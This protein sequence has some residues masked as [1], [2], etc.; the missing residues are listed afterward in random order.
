MDGVT[1]LHP[2]RQ[3][4]GPAPVHRH[5]DGAVECHPGHEPAKDERAATTP[6][7]PDA[8]VGLVPVL[9]QPVE[10]AD[11]VVPG[12]VADTRRPE[13]AGV[14]D[15]DGV[16]RLAVDVQLELIRCIVADA[17]GTG[18]HVTLEVI[19]R[20]FDEIGAAVDSVH[21]LERSRGI[22][23]LL[24]ES[25]AQPVAEGRGLVGEPQSEQRIHRE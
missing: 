25:L 16:E 22:A 24:F 11:H 13:G 14:R 20:F 23:G 17:H 3:V 19:E 6:C 12:I 18:A 10:D 4:R 21:D 5:P 2:A 7:L 15:I 9:A 1:R 8:L